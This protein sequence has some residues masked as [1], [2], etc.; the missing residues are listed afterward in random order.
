MQR[1]IRRYSSKAKVMAN[2]LKASSA[3]KNREANLSG[4]YFAS[5]KDS[6]LGYYDPCFSTIVLSD[7]LLDQ[8]WSTLSSVYRHELAHAIQ[9]S[10]TRET[11]HNQLF[12]EICASLGIESEYS[13][14]KILVNKQKNALEKI[15]KLIALGDSPYGPEAQSALDKARHLMA[16]TK[17]EEMESED[18]AIYE[19]CFLTRSRLSSRDIA[20]GDM[21]KSITGI[22]I[23]RVGNTDGSTSLDAY[24]EKSQLEI[25]DYL[26]DTFAYNVEKAFKAAKAANPVL[27]R[28]ITAANSYYNGVA[29][30]IRVRYANETE[31]TDNRQLVLIGNN[32]EEKA[33]RI[34][35]AEDTLKTT[36]RRFQRNEKAYGDGKN[37]GSSLAIHEG[38]SSMDKGERYLSS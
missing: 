18:E 29:S 28:G 8:D 5:L 13:K 21:V 20:L 22:F 27:Y 16:E 33:L 12:R 31:S 11:G 6:L 25:A 3:T 17:T 36:T 24:G 37:F 35:F 9:Y 32:A 34:R 19:L 26:F 2:R 38:V 23:V 30:A 10:R 4:V 1:T 14:A 15:K 7:T